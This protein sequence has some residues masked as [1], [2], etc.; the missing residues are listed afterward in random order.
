MECATQAFID[1]FRSANYLRGAKLYDW[2]FLGIGE[3][4]M[5]ASNGLGLHQFKNFYDYRSKYDLLVVNSSWQP[6]KFANKQLRRQID[7]GIK[8]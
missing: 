3:P 7:S 8:W 4:P 6:E 2:T 1:P 5:K